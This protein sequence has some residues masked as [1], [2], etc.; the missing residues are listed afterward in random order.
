MKLAYK[1]MVKL[2]KSQL[3][4]ICLSV[5]ALLSYFLI[6]TNFHFFSGI[7]SGGSVALITGIVSFDKKRKS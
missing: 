4:G 6:E 7:L 2:S 3:I 1:E 5:I